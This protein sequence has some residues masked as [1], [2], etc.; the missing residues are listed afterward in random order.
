M[1]YR[2]DPQAI[3]IDYFS[4]TWSSLKFYAFPPFSVIGSM[5]NKISREKAT[6]ICVLPAWPTQA[7][8]P[9]VM[10]MLLR[11]GPT[12]LFGRAFGSICSQQRL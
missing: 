12:I 2:P 1:S 10:T 11:A 4:I 7:W 5:I 9:Q 6:G 8:Y 3:D